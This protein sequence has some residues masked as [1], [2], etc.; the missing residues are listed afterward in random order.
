MTVHS[1]RPPNGRAP[2]AHDVVAF[3][4]RELGV[5]LDLYGRGVAIGAWRDYSMDF[6]RER[7]VFSIFRHAAEHPIYRIEKRPKDAQRQGA[8]S[9]VGMDG[10]IVK[11]GRELKQVLRV[12]DTKLIRA[13]DQPDP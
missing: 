2:A 6:L 4:R 7:A 1:F 8:Y 5:V 13:V 12:L 9:V 11:R 3:D 10:R